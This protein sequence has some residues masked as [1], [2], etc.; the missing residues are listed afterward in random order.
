MNTKRECLEQQKKK[1]IVQRHS[2]LPRCR[3][4]MGFWGDAKG[5]DHGVGCSL[6]IVRVSS[7]CLPCGHLRMSSNSNICHQETTK[8]CKLGRTRD[9]IEK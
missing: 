5:C 7:L 2:A 9:V 8:G 6:G 1:N 3:L 4:A